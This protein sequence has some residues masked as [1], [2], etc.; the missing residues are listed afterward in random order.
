MRAGG[1]KFYVICFLGIFSI[2][3]VLPFALT[4]GLNMLLLF[5]ALA[6]F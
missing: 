3:F 4:D 5:T 6:T 1:V 2:R